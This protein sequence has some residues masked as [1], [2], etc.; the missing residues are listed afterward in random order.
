MKKTSVIFAMASIT[1]LL[2]LGF[3]GC[4][5]PKDPGVDPEL[6]CG[7]RAVTVFQSIGFLAVYPEYIDVCAG[8]SITID[9]VP[10]GR[11][12]RTLPAEGNPGLDGWL[13]G[14]AEGGRS[15]VLTVPEDATAGVYKYG[16]AVGDVGMLDP[17]I[18]VIRR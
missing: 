11:S 5:T 15:V 1:S 4:A 3:A 12:L 17:R 16:I 7:S 14:G 10:R 8:Q 13:S 9:A 18:R 2:S 6:T